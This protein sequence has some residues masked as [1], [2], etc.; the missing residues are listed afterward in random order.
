MHDTFCLAAETFVKPSSIFTITTSQ[1]SA[2]FSSMRNW[3]N[4]E[5]EGGTTVY[6]NS[7]SEVSSFTFNQRTWWF[8][9]PGGFVFLFPNRVQ[10]HSVKCLGT[11]L[12]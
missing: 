11:A 5:S 4:A 12:A 9:E 1:D 10:V 2:K 8:I 7:V 6:P 3:A